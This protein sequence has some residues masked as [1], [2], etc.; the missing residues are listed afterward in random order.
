MISRPCNPKLNLNCLQFICRLKKFCFPRSSQQCCWPFL[1][2]VGASLQRCLLLTFPLKIV[3]HL[4]SCT[5]FD[6]LCDSAAVPVTGWHRL[7]FV[8]LSHLCCVLS[9]VSLSLVSALSSQLF[10]SF[11]YLWYGGLCIAQCLWSFRWCVCACVPSTLC[12]AHECVLSHNFLN[13]DFV[14]TVL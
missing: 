9:C 6:V 5:T 12:D 14:N 4:F 10:L 1:W 11:P 8:R 2:P 3:Q 7:G 13:E